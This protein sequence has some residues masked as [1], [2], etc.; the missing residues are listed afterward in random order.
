MAMM[1]DF[2]GSLSQRS[3]NQARHDAPRIGDVQPRLASRF[4]PLAGAAPIVTTQADAMP[5]VEELL[6]A[7][8]S[9][10]SFRSMR[11]VGDLVAEVNRELSVS[12]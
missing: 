7:P 8:L 2:L 11:T 5:Q 4:E 3:L 1:N 10:I 9:Y 6:D 12:K